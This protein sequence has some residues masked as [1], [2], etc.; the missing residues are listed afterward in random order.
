MREEK[1]Q[2]E[3][4]IFHISKRKKETPRFDLDLG[5]HIFNHFPDFLYT[6]PTEDDGLKNSIKIEKKEISNQ[7]ETTIHYNDRIL[8]GKISSTKYGSIIKLVNAKNKE[9]NKPSYESTINEGVE[10]VFF[11]FIYFNETNDKG[12][13]FLERNGVYGINSVFTDVLKLYFREYFPNYIMKTSRYIDQDINAKIINDGAAKSI[14]LKTNKVSKDI[15]DKLN[16]TEESEEYVY[17]L[18]IRKK[19]GFFPSN[20]RGVIKK[21]FDKKDKNYIISEPLESIG[22][23]D[24]SDVTIGFS[25]NNKS[26]NINFNESIGGVRSVYDIFVKVD[27][28][29]E[30]DLDS[31]SELAYEKLQQI[32]P[33]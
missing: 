3:A 30:S 25:Y 10:K 7:I 9:D 4:L 12:M 19:N 15:T 2:L 22:F 13:I 26:K 31:I 21:L 27:K 17:E 29:G 28:Y 33:L 11:F 20:T 32:N 8:L 14:T 1:R 23:N 6:L 24:K 5:K 18:V 16:L